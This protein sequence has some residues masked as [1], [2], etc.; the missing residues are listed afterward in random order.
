MARR[1]RVGSRTMSNPATCA[2]PEDLSDSTVNT[3]LP[4]RL[5]SWAAGRPFPVRLLEQLQVL[6]QLLALDLVQMADQI[7]V[8]RIEGS[9]RRVGAPCVTCLSGNACVC[10]SGTQLGA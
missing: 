8:G 10:P 9:P 2:P 6:E 7:L 5:R 4:A 3:A 1:T